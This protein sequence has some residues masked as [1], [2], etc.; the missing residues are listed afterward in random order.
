V[1]FGY[2]AAVIAVLY[3]FYAGRGRV[4]NFVAFT[5]VL[6]EGS[7][8]ASAVSEWSPNVVVAAVILFVAVG[9]YQVRRFR[10]ES[11]SAIC[12][13]GPGA[14]LRGDRRFRSGSLPPIGDA[15]PGAALRGDIYCYMGQ[16]DKAIAACSDAIRLNPKNAEA[17]FWRGL[18]YEKKDDKAKAAE[19]FEQAKRL[20]YKEK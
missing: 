9:Y 7:L 8:V 12:D 1:V 11:L 20:G 19:D 10:A 14:A 18:A 6:F 17:Y 13:A 2:P 16:Y 15:R 5:L 3:G 4:L